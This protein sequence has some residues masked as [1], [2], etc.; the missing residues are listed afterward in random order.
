VPEENV[1][2]GNV[3]VGV[4]VSLRAM[5]NAWVGPEVVGRAI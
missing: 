5:T 1:M 4:R 3:E 2:P